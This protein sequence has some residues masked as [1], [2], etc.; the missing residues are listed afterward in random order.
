MTSKSNK[1]L[2]PIIPKEV[3]KAPIKIRKRD[4]SKNSSKDKNNQEDNSKKI[5]NICI[6]R[7]LAFKM[8]FKQERSK[9]FAVTIKNIKN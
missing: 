9:I 8:L 1:E 5:L 2:L 6:V 4:E 7:A 3:E